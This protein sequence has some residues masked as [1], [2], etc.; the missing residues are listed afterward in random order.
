MNKQEKILSVFGFVSNALKVASLVSFL[1]TLTPFVGVTVFGFKDL[2]F[3]GTVSFYAATLFGLLMMQKPS[4]LSEE[5][6]WVIPRGLRN[7]IS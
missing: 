7:F 5:T 6:E 3:V 1:V 2:V 4:F